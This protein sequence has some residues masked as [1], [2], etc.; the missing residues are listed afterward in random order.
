MWREGEAGDC[1]SGVWVSEGEWKG[2]GPSWVEIA[3]VPADS[4]PLAFLAASAD[5]NHDF[6]MEPII[7]SRGIKNKLLWAYII[8]EMKDKC[9]SPVSLSLKYP[10]SV[11]WRGCG[12][13]SCKNIHCLS[14]GVWVKY[15]S[16]TCSQAA[17]NPS[18][19]TVFWW[20][21]SKRELNDC[22]PQ[23]FFF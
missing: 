17:D 19:L 3:S 21:T 18:R 1:K 7:P 22:A 11:F 10:S 12:Y 13:F 8:W 5:V 9:P 15:I 4:G 20:Y 16:L 6:F 14:M 2:G 23:M